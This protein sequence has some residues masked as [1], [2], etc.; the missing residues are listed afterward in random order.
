MKGSK[1]LLVVA[2]LT[3]GLLLTG[4]GNKKTLEC[5][6]TQSNME[7]KMIV[8]F[9]SNKLA[10]ITVEYLAPEDLLPTS[11]CE[12]AKSTF[13]MPVKDCKQNNVGENAK[14]SIIVDISKLDE[15]DKEDMN[16]IEAAKEGLEES[17]YTCTI[18]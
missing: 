8:N 15:E 5:K 12:S 4:C 11:V 7:T 1:I 6:A 9:E 18:K 16:D 17:G 13:V 3:V 14:V 10:G 2:L